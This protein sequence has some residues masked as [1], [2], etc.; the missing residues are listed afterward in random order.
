MWLGRQRAQKEEV[1]LAERVE[2]AVA[3]E[4][5]LRLG[6][7]CGGEPQNHVLHQVLQIGLPVLRREEKDTNP[8]MSMKQQSQ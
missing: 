1:V 5:T 8:P 3:L 4:T 7:R 2:E 6:P